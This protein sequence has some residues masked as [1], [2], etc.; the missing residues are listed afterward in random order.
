MPVQVLGLSDAPNAGDDLLVVESERKAREVALYRQG[1]VRDVRLAT[2][3]KK[4][5][6]V[7]SQ[8]GS[9]VSET[10]QLIVK[11]DV[12]G[13]AEA[14]RD[15]LS[16]LGNDEVTVRVIASGVGGITESDVTLAIASR[17][18]IIGF[19]VRA[20]AAARAAIKD[21]GIDVRYYSI[22]YEAIDDVKQADRR[23]C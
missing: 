11:A 10:V 12:Q 3:A 23:S 17:A 19:N 2:A 6:D 5:E 15:S 9:E 16:Q 7:F 8:M 21:S 22:I 18:R 14:L 13:S 20:D 4:S 1:K